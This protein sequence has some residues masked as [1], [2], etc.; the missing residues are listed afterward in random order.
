[1]RAVA[2]NTHADRSELLDAATVVVNLAGEQQLT[3]GVRREQVQP[4]W[5]ADSGFR[6]NAS[7]GGPS[8]STGNG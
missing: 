8:G 3:L 2:H 5:A 1:M 4:S 6:F 7:S